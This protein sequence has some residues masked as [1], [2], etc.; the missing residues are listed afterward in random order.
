[1]TNAAHSTFHDRLFRLQNSDRGTYFSPLDPISVFTLI[2]W[3]IAR[4]WFGDDLKVP[5]IIPNG[6]RVKGRSLKRKLDYVIILPKHTF[7]SQ[8]KIVNNSDRLPFASSFRV[9]LRICKISLVKRRYRRAY[10]AR[11]FRRWRSIYRFYHVINKQ[12][13]LDSL[14]QVYTWSL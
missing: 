12:W 3:C 2:R 11:N 6:R 5:V 13:Q 4:D 10:D 8:R 14:I 9:I 7:K 1:M